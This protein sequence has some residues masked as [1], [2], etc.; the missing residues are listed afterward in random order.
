MPSIFC[1][2]IHEYQSLHIHTLASNAQHVSDT[3]NFK[4]RGKQ[5]VQSSWISGF[6]A[7][8]IQI[9]IWTIDYNVMTIGA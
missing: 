1:A 2:N 8:K 7:I 5:E 6:F 9:V 4:A 3:S